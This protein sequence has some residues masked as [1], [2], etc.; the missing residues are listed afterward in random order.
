MRLKLTK[1]YFTKECLC[2]AK[3]Y[4]NFFL[5]KYRPIIRKPRR[6]KDTKATPSSCSSRIQAVKTKKIRP[7][8]RK[9]HKGKP[10]FF[11]VSLEPQWFNFRLLVPA[12]FS[13]CIIYNFSF[14]SNGFLVLDILLIAIAA[15][16]SVFTYA[17][18]PVQITGWFKKD[19]CKDFSSSC[20]AS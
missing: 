14:N 8:R 13:R 20:T 17:S 18:A 9:A 7:R 15:M 3:K 11:F 12:P 4:Q 6:H 5:E 19:Y 16:E 10:F 2:Y 1:F